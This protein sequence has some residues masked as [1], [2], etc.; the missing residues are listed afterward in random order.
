DNRL[1]F[2]NTAAERGG[3]QPVV[4]VSANGTLRAEV[5]VG[6]DVDFVGIAEQPPGV[7]VIVGAEWDY[8]GTGN[9]VGAETKADVSKIELVGSH[10]YTRAGT[11]FASFRVGAHRHGA[12]GIGPAVTNL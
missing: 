9:Y 11:Y 4:S 3:V 12:Q 7:G 10:V 6:E 8:E 2:A 5:K 1:V